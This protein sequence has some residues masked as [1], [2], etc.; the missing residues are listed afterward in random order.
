MSDKDLVVKTADFVKAKF[1][2]DGSGHDWWHLYRVWQLAKHI[3]RQESGAKML[4]VE[5]AALLHD[6]GDWKF[7]DA[8]EAGPKAA[9]EWLNSIDTEESI[10]EQVEDIVRNV[11]Y[12]GAMVKNHLPS[13][14][15][16]I[17]WDADKLDAIGAIGIARCFAFGGHAGHKMYEPSEV[18]LLHDSFEE[19]KKMES[20]SITHFYEKLLLLKDKMY[21]KTGKQMAVRRHKFMEDYLK[22]FYAEWDSE[23]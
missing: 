19:Y 17:I 3:A 5:L 1:E 16:R 9:R 13:I 14:E 23:L 8:A 18:P 10:T 20:S 4:V 7:N 2:N 11:S 15:G 22:E 21:T 6:I 12:K